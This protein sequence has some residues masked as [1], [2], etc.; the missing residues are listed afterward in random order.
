MILIIICLAL[1][2]V[3]LLKRDFFGYSYTPM[4]GYFT[5]LLNKLS[6]HL[7][8]SFSAWF[9]QDFAFF[10]SGL[11]QALQ[12]TSWL[13]AIFSP[14]QN[15]RYELLQVA[16]SPL[17]L[18]PV[19]FFAVLLNHVHGLY[20]AG[21][22]IAAALFLSAFKKPVGWH[23]VFSFCLGVAL[24]LF[25]DGQRM[26]SQLLMIA[27][28]YEWIFFLAQSDVTSL[29]VLFAAAIA[30]T[31]ILQIEFLFFIIALV[32]LS[33]GMLAFNNALALVS[34]E[35]LAIFM[36]VLWRARQDRIVQSYAFL[37]LLLH[38]FYLFLA[39][40]FKQEF[41][42]GELGEIM[43]PQ[44]RVQALIY[45]YVNFF[46]LWTGLTLV[47]G[48]FIFAKVARQNKTS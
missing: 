10:I 9:I 23:V 5:G 11:P 29:L 25:E 18:W 15:Q 21:A 7:K 26:S 46:V 38:S 3:F 44:V 39:L 24:F 13:K 16:L 6:E 12:K 14:A 43:R 31:I 32:L 41:F 47:L 20:V 19:L 30:I 4:A 37:G 35:I 1:S 22:A 8:K 48:H 42:G 34:G 17:A 36:V 28:E 33:S 40:G 2:I 27:H 45:Y